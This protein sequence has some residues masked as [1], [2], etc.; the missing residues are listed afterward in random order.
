MQEIKVH[1]HGKETAA[2]TCPS[3]GLRKDIAVEQFRQ[4]R[5]TITARCRC[6]SVF[7]VLFDF[8][9]HYHK[10]VKLPGAYEILG[11]G[12]GKQG[13]IQ[14]HDISLGG[15]GFTTSGL[16]DIRP[17]QELLI[18]FQLDDKQK[19]SLKKQVIVRSVRQNTIGCCFKYP[20]DMEKALGFYLRY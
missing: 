3:C 2:L 10:P 5:H 1:V 6:Q 20:A 8:R 13:L 15:M 9:Q 18:D 19:T 14:I 11:S 4:G 12:L 17:G 16:H 7:N